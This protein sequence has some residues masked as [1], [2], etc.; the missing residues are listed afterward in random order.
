MATENKEAPLSFVIEVS[1]PW[2]SL[3]AE[4]KKT[5]EGRKG[6]V[7]WSRIKAGSKLLFM[8]AKEKKR[9]VGAKATGVTKYPSIEAY[10]KEEGVNA[11]LPGVQTQEEGVA[12]YRSFWTNKEDIV[13]YGVLGIRFELEAT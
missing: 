10:L 3:I 6:T 8:E 11:C 7:I 13:T 5:V 1:E 4:G 2:F 9:I 12:V